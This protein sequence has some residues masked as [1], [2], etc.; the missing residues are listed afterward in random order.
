MQ[1]AIYPDTHAL[2][3]EAAQ[4]IVRLASEAIVTRGRFSIAL[5]G[6]ST[7]KVLYALLGDEPYRSQIDW[8][9]VDIFWSD[10]RCV[11]PDSEDSNYH[12]ALQVL[13]GK[14]AIP[15]NQVHRMPADQADRDAASQAYSADMQLTFGTNGIP[16]F[17]LI[18]LG[19]GPEG[20]TASLFPH[21]ASLHEQRRLVIPV[22]V[23]KPPPPR[24]TFTPPLLNAARHIL[25][26]VTGA[27]KA[28]AVQAV[29]EGEY[30]PDE[31]P[32]QIVRPSNGE[33]VWMLDTAAAGK[34]HR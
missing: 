18:Q 22:S 1:I 16:N 11:P 10:E 15:T 19:M 5:S 29:L 30:Q 20:H 25:F 8:S 3:S 14:I 24:L 2:S 23:P 4:Y 7:P 27:E 26:L 13:L 6:G 21:Q 17:D 33:V 31:Y 9:L 12:L 32:A 28:D 34:L